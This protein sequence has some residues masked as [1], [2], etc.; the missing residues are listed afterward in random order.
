MFN[1]LVKE[2]NGKLSR[3]QFL[4]ENYYEKDTLHLRSSMTHE[5]DYKMINQI[6][7]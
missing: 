3:E 1:V 6:K 7:L 2:G 5:E 4:K